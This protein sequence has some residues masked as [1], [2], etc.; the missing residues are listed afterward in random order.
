[1]AASDA[2]LKARRKSQQ[3]YRERR[4]NDPEALMYHLR[5]QMRANAKKR[6]EAAGLPFAL[7]V[8]DIVI[9]DVCPILGVPLDKPTGTKTGPTDYAPSLDR[10][11]P[12]LGY[13]PGNVRVISYKANRLR[14]NGTFIEIMQVAIDAARL[15]NVHGDF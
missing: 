12:A 13:V 14:N 9:P 3:R 10:I 4:K 15:H 1:M 11:R 6:A 8:D 2:T 7:A 5:Y